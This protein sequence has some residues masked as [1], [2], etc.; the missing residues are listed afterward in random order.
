[1][2]ADWFLGPSRA[3]RWCFQSADASVP[4]AMPGL[5]AHYV[6][7]GVWWFSGTR[8]VTPDPVLNKMGN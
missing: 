6:G 8:K 1:M 5:P 4:C 3:F 2:I 7:V